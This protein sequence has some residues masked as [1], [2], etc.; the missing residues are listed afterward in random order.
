LTWLFPH[1]KKTYELNAVDAAFYAAAPLV[2][3][4]LGNWFSGWLVD[5][6]YKSGKWQLSRKLPAMI[7]FF[8]AATGLI[9]SLYMNSV[10]GAIFFVSI[11]IFGADMTLPPSW[12][13]TVDVGRKNAGGVSGTMNMAGNV[14]SFVTALAFPYL[15]A[16]TGSPVPFFIVASILNAMAIGLWLMT[17]PDKPIEEF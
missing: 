5:K 4:A 16:W 9:A 12:S 6:I 13:F 14:G 2:A 8:L 11:A 10:N 1:V 15:L 3:G 17:K 7:G